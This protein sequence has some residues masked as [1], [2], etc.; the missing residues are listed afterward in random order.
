ML[1]RQFS[2]AHLTVLDC[3]PPELVRI[4]ARTGYDFVSLRPI[5]MGLPGE[6]NYD[7][8]TNKSMLKE[9]KDAFADTG[10]RLL[11]IELARIYDNMEPE[12]YL[13][14]F[15]V[16][17]ELGGRHVLSSIWTEDRS[18]AIEKFCEV[19]D[20]AYQFNLTVELEFVPIASVKNLSTT[21]DILR[22]ANRPNAG[23]MIDTHH[24]HRSG[25]LLED[26]QKV[27]DS[28]FR[29]LHLSDAPAEKPKSLE[30]M[31][32]ILREERL[33]VGEGGIDVAGIVNSIPPTTI[34]SIELPNSKRVKELGY[35]EFARRCL[36]TS[37]E[38]LSIHAVEEKSL[39]KMIDTV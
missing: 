8:A 5:F 22:T 6:P 9:T 24:F 28:Y 33:Y 11:D 10:I 23:L 35:E 1:T 19:C 39:R 34:C 2:I 27:P 4:A 14:A 31:Q 16:A 17:A 7:L 30:E 38:Y 15:E 13:S 36:K 37:K 26:L 3:T 29:F 21:L 20:L 12:N 18:Y 25:D 32:R